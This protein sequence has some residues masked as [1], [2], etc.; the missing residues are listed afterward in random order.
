MD[1]SEEWWLALQ[2]E[3]A[4]L[5]HH[6]DD[7]IILKNDIFLQHF[8]SVNIISALAFSKHNLRD[9]KEDINSTGSEEP[10]DGRVVRS[11]EP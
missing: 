8:D 7:V 10:G 1:C 11:L 6:T 9:T 2:S 4:F 3:N 5:C